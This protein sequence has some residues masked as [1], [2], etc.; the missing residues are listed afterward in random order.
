MFRKIIYLFLFVLTVN[1]MSKAQA[2]VTPTPMSVICC[3]HKVMLTIGMQVYPELYQG[4]LSQCP[5][6]CAQVY[7]GYSMQCKNNAKFIQQDKYHEF[8]QS[9][10]NSSFSFASCDGSVKHLIII[11]RELSESQTRKREND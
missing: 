7:P 3:G 5:A 9:M 11:R 10:P 1:S 4:V 8:Y 6:P 2:C